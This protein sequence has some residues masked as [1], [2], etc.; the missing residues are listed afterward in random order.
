MV[1]VSNSKPV[2]RPLPV[3]LSLLSGAIAGVTEILAMYP[4]D[5]VKTRLQLQVTGSQNPDAYK[6]I[7]D[8]FSKIFRNEGPRALY[9]GM[10]APVMVEA[11]KRA[12][13]F[14]ANDFYKTT[15]LD[16]GVKDGPMMGVYTGIGAGITE[17]Y[18]VV[19]F[20][21]VKIRLQDR[22][23]KGQYANTM[24]AVR[25]IY[26]AE[27]PMA[28]FRG[29]EAT[30]WRHAVWNAGYFGCIGSVRKVLPKADTPSG[31]LANNFIA[32]AIGGT[33]GTLLNTPFDVVKTRVQSTRAGSGS[34]YNW[35][36]PGVALVAREE[37]VAALYKGFVPKVLRLGPGGGI[38]LVVYD[39]VSKWMRTNW[40]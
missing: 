16:M 28:F 6:S 27:G 37:G 14:S 22:S 17:A 19:S 4:L 1:S 34:K 13:K 9:R 25:K 24:D 30:I 26:K 12:I 31:V 35:S 18:V 8:A 15:L 3:H 11:P 33:I 10:L 38:L 5:V 20:E 7:F 2:E 32:G 29:I 23:S 40:M 36:L 21:L 39:F